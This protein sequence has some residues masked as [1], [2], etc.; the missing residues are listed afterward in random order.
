MSSPD[1]AA[2]NATSPIKVMIQFLRVLF[3][4]N[5]AV[6]AIWKINVNRNILNTSVLIEDCSFFTNDASDL[7]FEEI[8]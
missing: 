3:V 5:R 6:S 4:A 2:V 1:M 7:G 8:H